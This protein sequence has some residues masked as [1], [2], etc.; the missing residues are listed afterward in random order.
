MVWYDGTSTIRTGTSMVPAAGGVPPG[1]GGTFPF[2][3]LLVSTKFM[4]ESPVRFHQK[5]LYDY[6]SSKKKRE[7]IGNETGKKEETREIHRLSTS[8]STY[9]C[10]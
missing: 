6:T 9:L 10:Q 4:Q 7:K 8:K 2:Y 1:T 3:Q 5:K